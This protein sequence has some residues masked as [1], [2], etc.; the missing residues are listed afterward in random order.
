M[1]RSRRCCCSILSRSW[2][3]H[4]SRRSSG[5][6]FHTPGL[7][8]PPFLPAGGMGFFLFA[9]HEV[10]PLCLRRVLFWVLDRFQCSASCIAVIQRNQKLLAVFWPPCLPLRFVGHLKKCR[11]KRRFYSIL[12]WIVVSVF[13]LCRLTSLGVRFVRPIFYT[14]YY[15]T[16]C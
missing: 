2:K 16:V 6:G 10:W 9:R 3:R 5:L 8:L 13:W 14:K 4:K 12:F 11:P 7:P 1:P 15:K